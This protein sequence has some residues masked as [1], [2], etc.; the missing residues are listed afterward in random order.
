MANLTGMP[1]GVKGRGLQYNNRAYVWNGR[2]R[3][4][5]WDGMEWNNAGIE[6]AS[7]TPSVAAGS[8]GN[9]SGTYRYYVQPVNTRHF[10]HAGRAV[11]GFPS[12]ISAE[13]TVASTKVTVGSIP[14]THA[15]SQVNA[16]HVYRNRSGFY[17]AD[18]EDEAQDFYY[19]GEVTLGTTTYTDNTADDALAGNDVVRFNQQI[20]A[21]FKFGAMYGERLFGV[22][23]DPIT[24]GLATVNADPTKVDFA[25]VSLPTGLVGCWF[26]KDGDTAQ[27]RVMARGSATQITL[28]R[29]FVGTLS[30]AA[31]H[32]YRNQWDVYF[33]EFM[34]PEASGPSGEA[35]RWRRELPG[36]DHAM[37]LISYGGQLLVFSPTNIYAI[38]GK[39]PAPEQI[40]ILPDPLFKGLGT[41]SG[42]SIFTVDDEVWFMSTRGPA[43]LT[44][45]G[46]ELVGAKLNIDWLVALNAAEQ[47]LISGGSNGRIVWFIAPVSGGTE[48]SQTYRYDRETN[49]GWW[50][51]RDLYGGFFVKD[52]GDDGK[53]GR[54]YVTQNTLLLEPDSGTL[55]VATTTYTGTVTTGGTTSFSNSGAAFPITGAGMIETTVHVF[56]AGSLVG[57][58]RVTANTATQ[59]TWASSGAGGGSLT[60]NVGDTYEIGN[61]WWTFLSRSLEIPG[62]AQRVLDAHVTFGALDAAKS[63]TKTDYVNLTA[64]TASAH[65]LPCSELTKK[66]SVGERGRDYALKLESRN[67]ATVRQ[68]TLDDVVK[69]AEK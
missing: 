59:L 64:V 3:M 29:A 38:H 15:D 5:K 58:R 44:P 47:A 53:Q 14:A 18:I 8:A 52:D 30:A 67:L 69:K 39:G 57:S 60:V 48:C 13:I 37:G 55:D 46:P 17:D 27:Y 23:F 7:F 61:P 40:K 4:Q 11:A 31:Y 66:W 33:S 10:N 19:L 62:Q 2:S 9:P 36:Q 34:D 12:T 25:S 21:T 35:F 63:V 49:Q 56:R 54:V 45:S 50:P 65:N 32:L 20:P 28:D 43:R 42:D 41:V 68:I 22:G 26:K 51:E 6:A 1:T 24:T 16:W